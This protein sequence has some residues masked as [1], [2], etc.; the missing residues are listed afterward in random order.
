LQGSAGALA[1][2]RALREVKVG[3][4]IITRSPLRLSFAGGG[5]DL[6]SYYEQHTG[7]LI[8]AAIDKYVCITLHHTFIPE[9]IIK[10]SKLERVT[11]INEIHHPIIRESL[12][13]VDVDISGL[14]IIS[15]TDIPA[16]AG[17]GSSGSFTTALLKA[18]HT[19]KK[20]LIHPQ[21]LA[22][23]AC[24]I[25]IE[26]LQGTIGKQDQYI[27][28]YGGLTCFQFQ[29]DGRVEACPLRISSETLY[30]LED[31][32]LLF[33][34]APSRS[35]SRNLKKKNERRKQC[36]QCMLDNLHFIKELGYQT[37]EALEEGDLSRFAKLLNVHWEHKKKCNG[38]TSNK[39]IER[40]YQIALANG[41][42]GGKLVGG[43]AFLMF[44]AEDK[45]RLRRAL[46]QTKLREVRFR[47]DFE[48][49]K[50][51]AA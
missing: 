26:R 19:Y 9:L 17:L 20:N 35:T 36:E 42:L 46:A 47:F 6:P 7:F 5:T 27:A 13:L 33:F 34:T 4:M 51:V 12:R 28:A 32:L 10:H 45:A 3:D 37:K 50:C 24:H 31:N 16:R 48:G 29:P 25:E 41:A 1:A 38:G 8:A 23:Q 21:D 30:N 40:W 43:G 11:D 2:N 44:Y 39:E 14:E 49:T 22:E 15:M 18:L